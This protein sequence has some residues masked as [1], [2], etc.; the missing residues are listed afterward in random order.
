MELF[1]VNYDYLICICISCQFAVA[2]KEITTHVRTRHST[3]RPSERAQIAHTIS[4]I[5][6]VLLDQAAAAQLRYPDPTSSPILHL[7]KPQAD[8][9]RCHQCRYVCRQVRRIQEHCR[10]EHGWSNSR[11][12]GGNVK[13]KASRQDKVPWTTGVLCQ[14]FFPS[15]AGSTWFEVARGQASGEAAGTSNPTS[16]TQQ[17]T[18]RIQQLRDVQARRINAGHKELIRVVNDKL[19]HNPWIDRVGWAAHLQGLDASQLFETTAA[20]TED[21]GV[22]GEMWSVID[23]VL[24]QARAISSP[25]NV[26]HAV[27]FEV[28][29]T[30]AHVKARRPFD[31]RM[32]EDTWTRYK[33]VWR[34]LLCVWFR[35]Q[36]MADNVRPPYK[37]TEVQGDA[38]DRFEEV[39][40][41]AARRGSRDEREHAGLALLISI[42]DHQLKDSQYQNALVS[43]LAVMGITKEGGWVDIR[44]YTTKYSAVIK[45]A[46]MLVIYQAVL[47]RRQE[48]ATLQKEMGKD[49]AEVQATSLFQYV[50]AK[51]RRFMTRTSGDKDAEPTPIDWILET[52]TYGLH[53]QYNTAAAGIIDW[54]G[55][56][57][58]YRRIR[59]TMGQLSDA[60]HDLVREGRELLTEL[61]MTND[62]VVG[63]QATY[64]LPA[65]PWL[66]IEDDHSETKV[67][68]SFLSDDRNGWVRQADGW[69][70]QRIAGSMELRRRWGL[71]GELFVP[72]QPEAVRTYG[73]TFEQFRERLWM[74]L[75]MLGGQ[76]GRATEVSGLRIVN[77][78]NGGVRNVFAHDSM[79]CFVTSYHKGYRTTGQAKVIHRYLPREVGELFV[80]YLWL[81]LPFWQ[82]VQGII[83]QANRYSAFLWA[84]ETVQQGEM[85]SHRDR[86][87]ERDSSGDRAC[88]EE[89][90][91]GIYKWTWREEQVW[92]TDRARR[93]LQHHSGRLL[94][95]CV[96]VSTWRHIAIGIAN[97]YLNEAFGQQRESNDGYGD[98]EDAEEEDSPWDL[99]AGHGTRVAGMVYAREL[100]QFGSGLAAKR[101]RFRQ[102]SRQWHR[103]LGFGVEDRGGTSSIGSYKRKPEV[104]DGER[105]E[106]RFRR[107]QRLQ[108]ANFVGQLRQMTEDD[109]AEFRGNQRQ[110]IIAIANGHS[111]VVQVMGTGGGK[112]LSFMLPAFCSPE[113]TTIVITPLVALRTDTYMRCTK[114][115]IT[116]DIWQSQ[117][118]NQAASIVFVTPES[119]VTKG[120]GD[121]VARL[122]GRQALDR[123]VVDECHVVLEST[124][125]FRPR[126]MELGEAIREIGVQTVCLTAT[127]AAADE[128]AFY[129]LMRF[130]IGRVRMF[131]VPTTRKNIRYAVR[132]VGQAD[133]VGDRDALNDEVCRIAVEWLQSIL[134]EGGQGKAIVYATSIERVQQLGEMLGCATFFSDVGST[135]NKAGRLEDWRKSHGAEGVI[136][137][138]N[139]LGLGIDIPDRR[140]SISQAA[141]AGVLYLTG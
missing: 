24:D 77:T 118:N 2:A 80:W 27:L 103:F 136:V 124:R 125:T 89:V 90:N 82:E 71:E 39:C 92:T 114:A 99:Q 20:I 130:D 72:F 33:A 12:R 47:E 76:P 134:K 51:V 3:I 1:V 96:N 55:D 22:L 52:R 11:A 106:A 62:D 94:G 45:V 109:T 85:S 117:K 141:S 135:E 119:A 60:L 32:E 139:A 137:A 93:I 111:P 79:M 42:L 120:F 7:A 101:Q 31:N 49:E 123:I 10:T 37:L 140:R 87:G 75:H 50:R 28:Q 138:T 107:F 19:E 35:T 126:L 97:R 91:D 5:P 16:P 69:V 9:I 133:E 83:Q 21:E 26:G 68:Y 44:D 56:R 43:A 34:V 129:R 74:L 59:F 104:Y 46:R 122:Q 29:R 66:S 36:D 132:V 127:L 65:I 81:V 58:S 73:Y 64:K 15:R 61:T 112:S 67:G 38:W 23:D 86:E 70:F 48:M 84:D 88:T 41:T 102:V 121:F 25:H 53:I 113:G 78:V 131:R 116:S 13:Q 95:S 98:E 63:D 6:G 100:M 14:R 18:D 17:A 4:N 57:V 115:G 30:E 54:V 110:T 8:G 40:K 128:A 108:R 105:L